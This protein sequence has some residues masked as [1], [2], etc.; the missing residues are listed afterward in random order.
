MKTYRT[1]DV[2]ELSGLTRG[3]VRTLARDGSIGHRRGR[4]YRF[5]FPDLVLARTAQQL[6]RQG[7]ALASVRAAL[8]RFT[9]ENRDATRQ[10]PNRLRAEGRDIVIDHE[11]ALFSV[12]T[13]QGI[14]DLSLE[15]IVSTLAP[16]VIRLTAASPKVSAEE[17]F[18][19]GC[20]L[21]AAGALE[22]AVQAYERAI[23]ADPR[24]ADAHVNL[25]RLYAEEGDRKA[26]DR[27][28]RYAVTLEPGNA[29]AWFNWGVLHQ[30]QGR[31]E[32]AIDAYRA[33]VRLDP[34]FADAHYNLAAILEPVDRRS[35]FRHLSA[36]K[37]LSLVR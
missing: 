17:W 25:G 33:A 6:L 3:Q 36:Y 30:E 37:R 5:Q 20:D 23:D 26:A 29:L 10:G 31:T 15:S 32:E 4:L 2:A 7:C 24:F 28:Y 9:D 21:E 22:Q 13:G 1:G 19:V 18:D 27:H 14:L 34:A 11:G 8:R 16:K 35:A 12:V